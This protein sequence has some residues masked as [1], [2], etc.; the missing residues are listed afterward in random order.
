MHQ[1]EYWKLDKTMQVFLPSPTNH[2]CVRR[3]NCSRYTSILQKLSQYPKIWIC[4]NCH[5]YPLKVDKKL[6]SYPHFKTF[7]L[8]GQHLSPLYLSKQTLISAAIPS[9]TFTQTN[10]HSSSILIHAKLNINQHHLCNSLTGI[11]S[12]ETNIHSPYML[13]R[14]S[15]R[16][17]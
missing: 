1:F 8:N 10:K 17:N 7:Q 3:V 15:T 5:Q 6:L 2:T 9:I 4:Q 11:T 16:A 13:N 12:T 14:T